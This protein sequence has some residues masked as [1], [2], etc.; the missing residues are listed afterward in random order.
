[1]TAPPFARTTCACAE[2]VRC[3]TTQPGMLAPGEWERIV[4]VI[5]DAEARRSFVAS[6]GAQ[7]VS[8]ETGRQYRIGTITPRYDRR[9]KR[10]VFLDDHQRCRIH[11]VAP[12]GCAYFDTHQSAMEGQRRS[13]WFMTEI[14]D[15]PE[16]AALR[17][18]LPFS[19][20][21]KPKG[22]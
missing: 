2:C 5:G 4:A 1:M 14:R 20:H 15:D 9:A 16:Y 10:C 17:A 13:Q 21:Y 3:C 19:D 18:T 6:P 11:A 12:A 8:M 7:V 22:Y